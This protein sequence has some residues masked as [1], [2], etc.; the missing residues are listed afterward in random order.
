[1][2]KIYI[3]GHKSPDCDS[4]CAPKAYEWYLKQKGND[5]EAFLLGKLNNEAKWVY[6]TFN[7]EEPKLLK[8]LPADTKVVVL[9]TT[10]PSQLPENVEQCNILEI[11]D[12]H[13][14]GGLKT[15]K[16]VKAVLEP[17]ACTCTI[18]YEKFKNEGLSMEKPI[19]GLLLSAILSDTLNST[20]P[21]TTERDKKAIEELAKIAEVDLKTHVDEQFKAK[22]SLEGMRI[23]EIVNFDA[24]DFEMS[25][26][27]VRIG[28]F[29]TVDPS[30]P[31]A[32]KNKIEEYMTDEKSSKGYDFF[33]YFIVD[34]LK[35]NATPLFISDAEK[36]LLSRALGIQ[37][38]EGKIIEDIVSR[39]KQIV[40]PL[41]KTLAEWK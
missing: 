26:K 24:K 28:V 25:R 5:A 23:E 30:Q 33:F 18:L 11:Y 8:Y 6:K 1:M 32:K 37:V 31:L 29:E 12:H 16:P 15:N 39:K 35:N 22:S 38:E 19:A 34:I 41:E 4:S 2:S 40:P 13:N 17:I 21:T 36:D 14:L 10:E 20:S 7:V 9:D 3:F 27:K